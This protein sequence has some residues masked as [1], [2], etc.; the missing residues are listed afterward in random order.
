MI[1]RVSKFIQYTLYLGD[2]KETAITAGHSAGI[3]RLDTNLI[4]LCNTNKSAA[5]ILSEIQENVSIA[6]EYIFGTLK[7]S[8]NFWYIFQKGEEKN[9]I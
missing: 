2:K 1:N 9:L 3:L 8:N 7:K 6:I 4:D 5:T